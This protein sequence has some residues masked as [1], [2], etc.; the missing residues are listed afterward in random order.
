MT[1][2]LLFIVDNLIAWFIFRMVQ[3]LFQWIIKRNGYK[4][5]YWHVY[6]KMPSWKFARI[7]RY[8]FSFHRCA[9]C[10]S[11]RYLDVHHKSYAHPWLEWLFFWELQILCRTCHNSKHPKYVQS[12]W[13]KASR[14]S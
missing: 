3:R 14:L 9:H 10:G 6:L 7:V 2:L 11:T 5:F 1:T 12:S 13:Q 8:F 4:W